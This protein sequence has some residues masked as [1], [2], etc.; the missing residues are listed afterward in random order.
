M[1]TSD[2][3]QNQDC[4]NDCIEPL[5]FP[6]EVKNRSG[7]DRISYRIGT[8]S[9]FREFMLRKLDREAIL[10][11]WTHREADDPGIALLESAAILG[12]ILTFYQELYANEAYLRTA[13]WRESVADLVRLLG[14]HLSPGI[15]GKAT[16]AFG[17]KGTNPVVIPAGFSV[18]AQLAGS[19]KPVDFETV[20]E[21]V[22]EPALSQFSLYR[23][24]VYPNIKTGD[25]TFAI[26]T[27]I[28]EKQQL[29]LNKGD[30]IV[31]VADP[32]NPQTARQ[33]AVIAE[34]RQHLDLT[35][36]AIEGSW[37]GENLNTNRI[38]AFK[39]GRS[40]RYFGYNAPPTVTVVEN[41]KAVQ[42]PVSFVAKLESLTRFFQGGIA[43]VEN[44]LKVTEAE[45]L[46]NKSASISDTQKTISKF[47]PVAQKL[48]NPP[49]EKPHYVP[50]LSVQSFPLDRAVADISPGAILLVSLQLSSDNSGLGTTYFFERR[51]TKVS[52]TSASLGALTGGTT[53]VQ[54]D[55]SVASL[56]RSYTDIRTVE[57][58]EVIGEQLALT[59]IRKAAYSNT[60]ISDL[61]FYGDGKTY[62]KLN[63]RALYL[64]GG[65]R[66]EQVTVGTEN[67]N[68]DD[69]TLYPI[70]LNPKLQKFTLEDFPLDKPPTVVARGNLVTANQGKTEP[71]AV[72]GNGDSRQIFQTFKLPKSPL[73]YFNSKSETPPEVPE[74]EIY[75]NDRL[76]QRVQSLFNRQPKEEIY[77]VREDGNGDSWVQFGDGKTGARL[78]S[79][80]NNVVAKY[81]TG[82]GAF[83]ALKTDTTVQGG[84]LDR[85]DKIWLPG[86]ATGGEQP[87]TGDNAKEAAPG[88]I[89]SLG[90]LVSLK[91]FESETLAISGVA[92]VAASWELLDNIPTVMLTVLMERGR[93]QEIA[94]IR[95]ILNTYNRCR[96]P[97]RF[98]IYVRP[99]KLHYVYLDVTL[100]INPIFREELVIKA[101]KVALGIAGDEGNGIDGSRGLFGIRQRQFGHPEYAT[102]IAGTI[103]NIEGVM[104]VKVNNFGDLGF[105]ENPAN[106]S[107]PNPKQWQP[108]VYC[109]SDEI[110]S[111]Y[112]EPHLQIG[113]ATTISQEVC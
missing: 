37:Q 12:D 19:D 66:A 21:F 34:T 72:L 88:K 33:I 18:K 60:D 36:I 27:S 4:R 103:Q 16:F 20:S 54:I 6:K 85:L 83:G 68:Q 62:Q 87:E 102:R 110:L 52:A 30:R 10:A 58:H 45:F 100:G 56:D 49:L 23:P 78:P 15:G 86:I 91:D 73:T 40:F 31:L 50:A 77:I 108:T 3:Q 97:Q 111:L 106:L 29:K 107:V 80:L 44:F 67:T 69:I 5:L 35:E 46:S 47:K 32:T 70:T 113:P 38:Y 48:V 7:L 109:N 53:V 63:G 42:K 99:G 92:K 81:R 1:S 112:K 43:N 84:K 61:Y 26:A 24:F 17:V 11:A 9:D 101:V 14:Y 22:A 55:R 90:R 95:Q 59:S 8:Y 98:P 39:L 96:G 104:W 75:V 13:Q 28:L 2:E 105:A 93:E 25:K 65:D 64:V 71:E 79:G 74:L 89:Q 41:D 51:I 82:I 94:E 76:W 57:F